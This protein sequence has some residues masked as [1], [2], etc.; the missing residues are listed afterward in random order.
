MRAYTAMMGAHMR[1]QLQYRAAA[2]AGMVTQL[3]FGMVKL[4]IF[5]AFYQS[6]KVEQ[7]FSYEQ[8]VNYI[9]LGQVLLMIL[10]FRVDQELADLIRMGNLAYE[11]TRPVKIFWFWYVR[12]LSLRIV[13]VLLRALPMI[14]L[15]GLVFPLLKLNQWALA[16]PV[17]WMAAIV[18]LSSLVLAFLLSAALQVLMS[19]TILWSM[20]SQGMDLLM[21][22]IVWIFSGIIIPL[23]FYPPWMQKLFHWMPFRGLIDIPLRIYM[24]HIPV[25]AAL[26]SLAVQLT[27]ILVL[28]GVSSVLLKRGLKRVVI[29]GG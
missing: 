5:G 22:S 1:C 23:P 4:M 27:W 21:P 14:L 29:Q 15:V 8:M 12:A 20:S 26:G 17:S 25:N 6:T 7:P 16:P 13:P 28:L 18:F 9:W 3:F 24:G 19:V 2:W 11:L 10:P